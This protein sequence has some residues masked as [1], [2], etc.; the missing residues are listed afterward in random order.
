[1][2]Y[3]PPRTHYLMALYPLG[4]KP[5]LYRGDRAGGEDD[6]GEA[7]T[8]LPYS[9]SRDDRETEGDVEH[10]QKNPPNSRA[11]KIIKQSRYIEPH[12]SEHVGTAGDDGIGRGFW[13]QQRPANLLYLKFRK[14][15]EKRNGDN[16]NNKSNQAW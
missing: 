6:D 13:M 10:E 4:K 14:T 9:L 3:L 7:D 8:L 15:E 2:P 11:E 1:M 5:W 16:T 12:H